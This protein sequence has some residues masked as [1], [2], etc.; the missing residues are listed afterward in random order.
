MRKWKP[1]ELKKSGIRLH[2]YYM[3][4]PAH[5]WVTPESALNHDTMATP[6]Y[7][8]HH[9]YQPT[10]NE[11]FVDPGCKDYVCILLA[12]AKGFFSWKIKFVLSYKGK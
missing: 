2:S 8:G 5:E 1:E 11:I 12:H 10:F 9:H 3:A 4:I 6:Y 7:C